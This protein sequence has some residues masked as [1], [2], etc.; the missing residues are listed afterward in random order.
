MMSLMGELWVDLRMPERSI[1]LFFA[2]ILTVSV[3]IDFIF[4]LDIL[5]TS[6]SILRILAVY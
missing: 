5:F 4:Q 1:P 6:N 3:Y 2:E